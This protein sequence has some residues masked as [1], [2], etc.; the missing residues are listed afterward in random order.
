M[1]DPAPGPERSGAAPGGKDACLLRVREAPNVLPLPEGE[2]TGIKLEGD[3]PDRVG[4]VLG[5]F[6]Q[7]GFGPAPSLGDRLT[8]E[9]ISTLLDIDRE[10]VAHQRASEKEGRWLQLAALGLFCTFIL[11]LV[12]IL[13]ARGNDQ[14]T[15]KVLL[16]VVISL[17]AGATG[18]YGLGRN[19]EV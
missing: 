5:V 3:E 17:V 19:Q 6:G 11:A 8:P 18:G 16:A 14:L 12:S 2:S 9:H 1:S 4:E 10:R 13:L 15:E 7:F